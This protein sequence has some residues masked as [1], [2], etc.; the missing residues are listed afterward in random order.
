MTSQRVD[1]CL[2]SMKGAFE[3]GR[4]RSRVAQVHVAQALEKEVLELEEGNT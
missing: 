2:E 3:L 1:H 4:G